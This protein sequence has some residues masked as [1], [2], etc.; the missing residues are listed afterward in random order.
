MLKS[1]PVFLMPANLNIELCFSSTTSACLRTQYIIS[2]YIVN[3]ESRKHK[4][5]ARKQPAPKT[6][7]G[8]CLYS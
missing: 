2:K 7:G 4:I 8:P 1:G 3:K 6:Q 5:R